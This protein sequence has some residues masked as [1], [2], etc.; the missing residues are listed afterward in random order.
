MY[1]HRMGIVHRDLKAENV[2]LSGD[3]QSIKLCDFGSSRD[4]FNPQIKGSGTP[5]SH[6]RQKSLTHFVGTPNF[7][8]P[9]AISNSENDILSDI[10]SLG[11]LFYQVLCGIP[12]FVAGSDYLVY[13]RIRA[14]DV[15][16]PP[17]GLSDPAHSLLKSII[18]TDRSKR[19]PLATIKLH[20]FFHDIQPLVPQYNY[21]DACI[22]SI[23]R[24]NQ[25]IKPDLTQKSQYFSDRYNLTETVA[26]WRDL[27]APGKGIA[28][29]QHLIPHVP[30]LQSLFPEKVA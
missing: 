24:Q 21:D 29:V 15:Q 27:S 11:C 22:R 23:V 6:S 3:L 14:G 2:L 8:S 1:M 17:H 4:L 19:P 26:K 28:M 16:I 7:L 13:V 30:E 5:S 25:S 12:P 20:E 18:Q 10:W 9:E